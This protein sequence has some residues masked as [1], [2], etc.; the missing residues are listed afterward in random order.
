STADVA[1]ADL[2][3]EVA[4][5]KAVL[6]DKLGILVAPLEADQAR[7]VRAASADAGIAFSRPERLIRLPAPVE[8]GFTPAFAPQGLAP[9]PLAVP[10]MAGV[11]LEY[12]LGYREGVLRLIEG[13]LA[14]MGVPVPVAPPAGVAFPGLGGAVAGAEAAAAPTT[15]ADTA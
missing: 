8:G 1:S 15:F 11:P 14:S 5:D 3:H 4:S 12:L 6:F 2:T 10:P 13:F 9:G 7:K